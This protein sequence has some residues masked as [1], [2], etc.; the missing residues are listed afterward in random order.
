MI[1]SSRSFASFCRN[2]W[3]ESSARIF[4]PPRYRSPLAPK[5]LLPFLP[6]HLRDC[7]AGKNYRQLPER[8]SE[9][10]AAHDPC[11][12]GDHAEIQD[13]RRPDTGRRLH[14]NVRWCNRISGSAIPAIRRSRNP[15]CLRRNQI[16]SSIQSLPRTILA[17]AEIMQKFKIN[18]GISEPAAYAVCALQSRQNPGT[19][20]VW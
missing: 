20:E 7:G 15:S 4:S 17:D 14:R 1:R 8:N 16:P 2:T 3:K 9:I 10:P 12:R 18:G 5:C 11:R 6:G 13:Q 19:S